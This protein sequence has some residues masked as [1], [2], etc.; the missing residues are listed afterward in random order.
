MFQ[1]KKN[2]R[3][4]AGKGTLAAQKRNFSTAVNTNAM[5]EQDMRPKAPRVSSLDALRKPR[6]LELHHLLVFQ[7]N[8]N[9]RSGDTPSESDARLR[10]C[11]VAPVLPH[12][13]ELEIWNELTSRLGAKGILITGKGEERA[14]R[15]FCL[16][17]EQTST[18]IHLECRVLDTAAENRT[19]LAG[20]DGEIKDAHIVV[21]LGE[22]SLA[23]FQA[24]KDRRGTRYRVVVWQN[25]PRPPDALPHSKLLMQT[26]TQGQASR[27]R[28]VRREVLR[29]CDALVALDKDSATWAYLEDV[30]AQRIR[31]VVRGV[32]GRR[33]NHELNE[34]RRKEIRKAFGFSENDF[35]YLQSGPLEM[36]A[37]ALD[38]VYAFKNLLQSHPSSVQNCKLVF[39]GTGSASPEVRQAVVNLH[40]DDKVFFIDPNDSAL[41]LH[42]NQL[43]SLLSVCDVMI[44]NPLAPVNGAPSR[45]VDCTFDVLC[46][47]ASGV[48]IV[49]NGNGWVGEWLGRFYRVFS[50]GSIHALAR[51]MHESREKA[52]KLVNVKRAVRK[53]LENELSLDQA[54]GELTKIVEGLLTVPDVS[55]DRDVNGAM[56]RIETTIQARQYLRAIELIE[57]AF[58]RPG[59]TATA[60]SQLFRHVGD[61]FTKL[62][63]LENGLQ[64]YARSLELDPYCAKTFIGLGTIALQTKS[65]NVAVPQFQK[66]VSLAPN[67]DMAS[68]GLGLAFEG[69]G[70]KSEA[71]RWTAR[72]CN[73]N[74]EN[75]VAIFNLVKLAYDCDTFAEA[76]DVVGRYV[77]LHPH[78]VNM[79]FT[80]GGLAYKTE[81]MNVAISLME[82][83]LRLDPMNGRAHALLQ[84]I[85]KTL[86]SKKQA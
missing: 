63:D 3:I 55:E 27:D 71:L 50:S 48:T 11:F 33:F 77:G 72:A 47:L 21:S 6:P 2:K 16:S 68:L 34:V 9:G 19:F 74:I 53:A 12:P 80:L 23:S 28:T 70:E 41:S 18:P 59:L 40:L 46:A 44:H 36:E 17:L 66:A 51:M 84:Q 54:C 37:G 31:R 13:C 38:T 42:G 81:R 78:D 29:A 85:K 43:S 35:I 76:E 1:V 49:S 65:Y 8:D 56:E 60:K 25:A 52:P 14:F 58:A 64:N 82:D 62:G 69:L 20:L 22:A 5:S 45:D 24:L 4:W 10:M 57:A 86:S 15:N 67:D 26:Q 75:T 30:S 39:C 83:I 73:L 32:N 61:C 7:G 79:L